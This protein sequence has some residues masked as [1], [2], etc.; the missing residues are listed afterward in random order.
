MS[1]LY[2]PLSFVS[3]QESLDYC[4]ML[5]T[6]SKVLFVPSIS[7]TL[8]NQKQFVIWD[9]EQQSVI[10]KPDFNSNVISVKISSYKY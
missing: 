1:L 5:Y 6:T 7:N 2:S 8:Y 10:G 9:D 4:E 3:E